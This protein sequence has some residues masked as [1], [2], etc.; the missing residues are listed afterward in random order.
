MFFRHT[1]VRRSRRRSLVRQHFC[2]SLEPRTLL[3]GILHTLDFEDVGASLTAESAFKGPIPG[4]TEQ[5]GA[6]GDQIVVGQFAVQEA[7]FNNVYSRDFDSWSGWGYSNRTDNTTAGFTNDLSSFSGAGANDSATYGVSFLDAFGP[8][9]PPTITL[10]NNDLRT[11]ESLKINNNTYAGLSMQLGDSFAKKFGG[12]TGADPDWFLLT[13][14]GK[15]T[16]GAAIDT[17]E[18]YLADY[19]FTDNSKDYVVDEWTEVFI[20]SLSAAKSLEFTLTS[21]DNG[22]FG[23]NTPAYFAIDDIKLSEPAADLIP[24]AFD[25]IGDHV[26]SGQTEVAFSVNNAGDKDAG[27]FSTHVVW[28]LNSIVGDDDDMVVP[29]SEASFSA[30]AAGDTVSRTVTAKLDKSALLSHSLAVDPSGGV[31]G[32]ISQD[33]SYLFVVV[34]S[35]DTVV[36]SDETNNAAINQ[37]VSSDDVTYFA[38]DQNGN[39]VVEPL[40]ALSSV[41]SVGQSNPAADLNGDGLVSPFEALSSLQRIGYV[42]NDAALAKSAMQEANP[43]KLE[44]ASKSPA[45]TLPVLAAVTNDGNVGDLRIAQTAGFDSDDSHTLDSLFA[46]IGE[47]SRSVTMDDR[48]KSDSSLSESSESEG[49]DWLHVVAGEVR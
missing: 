35:A 18:F 21:S 4:G 37:G 42:R 47:E 15:N 24:T 43:P 36:E 10:A 2:E 39:G 40:E 33:V 22:A 29:G 11:F 46:S 44:H 26:L 34:D 12:E 20:P 41:Q 8:S 38:W 23:M 45:A 14:T 19:R 5:E 7:L 9:G 27:A 28:S 32:T 3:T 1:N 49:A 13:I 17:V 25:A 48:T 6:F 16:D 30:L 31:V